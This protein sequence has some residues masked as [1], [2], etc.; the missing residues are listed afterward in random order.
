MGEWSSGFAG[1]LEPQMR[2]HN[3]MIC[4]ELESANQC[5]FLQCSGGIGLSLHLAGEVGV[6]GEVGLGCVALLRS[7]LGDN[8]MVSAI[9]KDQATT[10]EQF[11]GEKRRLTHRHSKVSEVLVAAKE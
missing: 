3:S 8:G 5:C 11:G 6:D 4:F 7:V 10:S 1:D 9:R 2:S